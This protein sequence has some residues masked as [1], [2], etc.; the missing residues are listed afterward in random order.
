[1]DQYRPRRSRKLRPEVEAAEGRLLL[2]V[3]AAF[4]PTG[5]LGPNGFLH[6]PPGYQ[7]V[8]P[9]T[10][11]LPFGSPLATATFL[12]PTASIANGKHVVLGQKSYVGPYATLTASTGFIKIGGNSAVLDNATVVANPSHATRWP[13]GVFIGDSVS[14]GY[15]ATVHG[16]SLI[17]DF[18]AAAKPT[19]VGANALVDNA[20]IQPGAV[21]GVLARVGPGVTV[22]SGMYVL[23][24]AN[25]TTNAEAS[26]PALG[27]VEALPA[28]VL[29]DLKTELTRDAQLAAGYT[30][31]YQG[32]TATGANVGVDP[33]VTP[34]I[35]HGNLAAVLGTSQQPGPTST[36]AATGISFEPSKTGPKFPGPY[37]A[38]VES[39]LANFPGRV[40]GDAR[41]TVR[42]QTV[43]NHLGRR[44]AIRADQGQPITFA[45]AP[46]TGRG[47]TINSPL[48]GAVTSGGVTKLTGTLTIGQNLSA[49]TGAVL[50]GG[51][52]ASY[53]VGDS[54]T[55][56]S[57][58]VVENSSIGTG[59]SIGA[60]AVVVGSTVAAGQSIA[61]GAVFINNKVVGQVEW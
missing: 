41:F 3:G 5:A 40:V 29:A 51:S 4:T 59:A 47:V 24:G 15:G 33:L 28:S 60:R 30:N 52:G 9:N 14:V 25:V 22:P 13:T 6:N 44:N 26:D 56:G 10:P 39:L 50:V 45:G 48:G 37:K 46:S 2:S 16:Q 1:M 18:G 61:P 17:G 34:G 27:K 19:G 32:N 58:A 36:S 7:A 53:T 31:L 57:H 35:N 23:P 20:T 55:I 21:V 43:A 12:D 38:Q 42:A 11:V 54:V 8:R 49:Q